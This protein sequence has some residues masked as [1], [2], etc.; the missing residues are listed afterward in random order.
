MFGDA[1]VTVGDLIHQVETAIEFGEIEQQ[2]APGGSPIFEAVSD[3][4]ELRGWLIDNS[5][6]MASGVG[7]H[8][9]AKV[10]QVIGAIYDAAAGIRNDPTAPP[11]ATIWPQL[12]ALPWP[13]IAAGTGGLLLVAVLFQQRGG[14]RRR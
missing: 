9:A 4:V 14:R 6:L 7:S 11:P 12:R 2:H 13:W 5:G 8:V 10:D 3:A 1:S